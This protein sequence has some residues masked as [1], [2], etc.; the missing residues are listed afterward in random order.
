MTVIRTGFSTA[1]K[2]VTRAQNSLISCGENGMYIRNGD[3]YPR[4]GNSGKAKYVNQPYTK[5]SVW[6]EVV[7]SSRPVRLKRV[8]LRTETGAKLA[9]SLSTAPST[10]TRRHYTTF[11]SSVI[12][13][14]FPYIVNP[15]HNGLL[16]VSAEVEFP[17]LK[18]S[19][20]KTL[21]NTPILKKFFWQ[22][23]FHKK[24]NAMRL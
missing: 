16:G 14:Y 20:L 11:A 22:N 9:P 24:C 19:Y 18:K 15:Q 3:K 6:T 13:H 1:E 5:N 4:K 21:K 12:A 8:L 7:S 10:R 2:N 17:S 23:N